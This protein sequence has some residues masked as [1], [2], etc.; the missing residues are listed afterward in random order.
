M[1]EFGLITEPGKEG[2]SNYGTRELFHKKL[3]GYRVS[4][5]SWNDVK[6]NVS[7]KTYFFGQRKQSEKR[8][9]NYSAIYLSGLGAIEGK[10]RELFEFI[11]GLKDLEG[12]VINN[13][14]TMIENFDK[15]YLLNLQ[16]KG[17]P[18]IPTEEVTGWD[19]K[20]INNFKFKGYSESLIKPRIF[21][22]RSKGIK[23]IKEFP[24]NK[25]S[26]EDFKKKYGEK[27]LLQPFI[28][29][30]TKYGERS[31][32]FVG[33]NFSHAIY[34]HRDVWFTNTTEKPAPETNP[35]R[36]ELKTAEKVFENWEGE[37]DITRIDFITHK[38]KSLISEVEMINPNL[39][40]GEGKPK[41]DERF[42]SLFNE[43]LKKKQNGRA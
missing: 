15:R 5:F 12:I 21:G 6:N 14:S 8:L 43:H 4:S 35:K 33:D 13:P 39:W 19:Y 1:K 34:R 26:F 42:M 16:E 3:E 41:V 40:L 38:G 11:R 36:E 32:V 9:Q 24:F 20:S 2:D 7:K 10:K 31:L 29:D 23:K 28:K 27:I 17:V 30:I 22:E 25:K 18:V 37:Y